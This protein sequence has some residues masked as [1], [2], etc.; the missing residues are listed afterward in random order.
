MKGFIYYINKL[1]LTVI[2]QFCKTVEWEAL[3]DSAKIWFECF[4]TT[5]STILKGTVKDKYIQMC[6]KLDLKI[7][8]TSSIL[9]D[10]EIKIW[11]VFSIKSSELKFLYLI[12]TS[13]RPSMF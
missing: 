4:L 10:T 9:T 13:K 6:C 2:D 11:Y 8:E 12:D 7:L 5:S 1:E 3:Q